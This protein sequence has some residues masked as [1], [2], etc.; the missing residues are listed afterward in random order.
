[1]FFDIILYFEFYFLFENEKKNE[2]L[3]NRILS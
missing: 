1:M 2:K 3:K